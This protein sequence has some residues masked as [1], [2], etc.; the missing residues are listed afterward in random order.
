MIRT[1]SLN[2][3]K[4]NGEKWVWAWLGI[5]IK[6][7]RVSMLWNHNIVTVAWMQISG[8]CH[9]W[10]IFCLKLSW[11]SISSRKYLTFYERKLSNVSNVLGTSQYFNAWM[12][13]P[14][15]MSYSNDPP[16]PPRLQLVFCSP[17]FVP[18]QRRLIFPS[19]HPK[20]MQPKFSNQPPPPP[21]SNPPPTQAINSDWSLRFTG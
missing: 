2:W 13:G 3:R 17:F 9:F 5:E 8:Y 12:G 19:Y 16:P 20:T 15:A 14:Q 21:L 18:C 11:W 4:N 6:C 1:K 7:K 10:N